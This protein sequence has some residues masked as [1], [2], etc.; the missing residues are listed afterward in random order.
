MSPGGDRTRPI[1]NCLIQLEDHSVLDADIVVLS[2]TVIP[3]TTNNILSFSNFLLLENE[4]KMVVFS[5]IFLLKYRTNPGE[6]IKIFLME[7]RQEPL[8]RPGLD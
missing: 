1:P 2:I 8:V 6:A 5:R 4:K 3:H 7:S